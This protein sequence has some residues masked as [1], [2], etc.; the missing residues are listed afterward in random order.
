MLYFIALA[1][2]CR[3]ECNYRGSVRSV[4]N[5]INSVSENADTAGRGVYVNLNRLSLCTECAESGNILT[6]AGGL[7]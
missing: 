4:T 6:V 7:L 2:S 5:A 1:L 3:G